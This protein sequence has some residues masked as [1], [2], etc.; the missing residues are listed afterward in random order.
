MIKQILVYSSC[1]SDIKYITRI[2]LN[3]VGCSET[4]KQQMRYTF[5]KTQI[6][7]GDY[8]KKFIRMY[9]HTGVKRVCTKNVTL[10]YNYKENV[11]FVF[12]YK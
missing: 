12:T 1:V 5:R 7:T 3:V 10:T 11:F 2:S 9:L 6:Q 4:F 8:F